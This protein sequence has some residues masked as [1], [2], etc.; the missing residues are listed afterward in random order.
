MSP[1]QRKSGQD[2]FKSSTGFRLPNC[3]LALTL[4]LVTLT[5]NNL[6]A[7]NFESVVPMENWASNKVVVY[8]R[9]PLILHLRT[10]YERAV[11]FPEP[12]TLYAVNNELVNASNDG[13]IN[14]C[15]IEISD[16]TM[17][18]SPFG[19]FGDQTVAVRGKN[20]GFVFELLV[21]S[22]PV[23]SRQPIEIQR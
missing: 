15:V 14:D 20:T 11:V 8:T 9:S 4:M 13:Q 18:F 16:D 7:Q 6:R 21:S 23:G 3:L 19:R 5:S 17:S 2:Q 1:Q 10:G 12:V 22:S